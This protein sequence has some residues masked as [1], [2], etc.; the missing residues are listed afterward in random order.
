MGRQWPLALI[1]DLMRHACEMHIEGIVAKQ[2]TRHIAPAGKKAAQ[3][4]M[5]HVALRMREQVRP[6]ETCQRDRSHF[7]WFNVL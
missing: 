3:S 1:V 5:P 7:R 6:N 4:A 2:T